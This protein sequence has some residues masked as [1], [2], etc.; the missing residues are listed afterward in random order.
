MKKITL[1]IDSSGSMQELKKDAQG[2]INQILLD[3]PDDK[4]N[5]VDFGRY[6]EDNPSGVTVVAEG[7]LG[8]DLEYELKPDSSTPLFD[9]VG[10][11]IKL[12]DFS[13]DNHVVLVTDGEENWSKNVSKESFAILT[14][15]ME[16]NNVNFQFVGIGG[17]DAVSS[18]VAQVSDFMARNS[19]S[20]DRCD[21]SLAFDSIS[22]NIQGDS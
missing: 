11:A 18:E 12:L 7:V 13:E 19:I 9:A 17:F 10:E 15:V 2:G 21:T 22:A 16:N 3:F 6:S 20:F 5:I 14:E 1:I 8:K 4:F